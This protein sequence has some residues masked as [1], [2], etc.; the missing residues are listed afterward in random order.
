MTIGAPPI[1]MVCKHRAPR[2]LK[3]KAFPDRIP[4]DI[5]FGR[6]LHRTPYPGDRGI[7]F[8]PKSEK[9]LREWA[10]ENGVEL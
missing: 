4:D 1:C 6:S 5:I 8:E 9:G 10:D 2:G 3:C 7:Q